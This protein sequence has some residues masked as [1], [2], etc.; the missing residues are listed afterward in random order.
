MVGAVEMIQW[1]SAILLKGSRFSL[2]D[3][4]DVASKL[5]ETVVSGDLAPFDLSGQAPACMWCW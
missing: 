3:P 5:P 1:L 4:H 2:E